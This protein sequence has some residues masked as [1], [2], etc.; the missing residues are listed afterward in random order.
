MAAYRVMLSNFGAPLH[1]K[2]AAELT[3]IM[4]GWKV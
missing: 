3:A 1:P 4:E 2:E